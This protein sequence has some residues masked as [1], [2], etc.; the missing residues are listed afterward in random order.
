MT[1]PSVEMVKLP[2]NHA[3]TMRREAISGRRDERA[4]SFL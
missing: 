1:N 4:E 3:L 2:E